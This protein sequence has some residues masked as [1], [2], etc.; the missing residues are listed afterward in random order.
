M[1]YQ[2]VGPVGLMVKPCCLLATEVMWAVAPAWEISPYV[3]DH[4]LFHYLDRHNAIGCGGEGL[5]LDILS[6]SK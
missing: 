3:S 1:S 2:D 4:T 5:G 6:F